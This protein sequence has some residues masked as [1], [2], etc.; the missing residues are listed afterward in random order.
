[1]SRLK[2]V[3]NAVLTQ[4]NTGIKAIEGAE[5][6]DDHYKFHTFNIFDLNFEI[7]SCHV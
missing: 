5:N 3:I 2:Y 1:M 7:L 4:M 6:D